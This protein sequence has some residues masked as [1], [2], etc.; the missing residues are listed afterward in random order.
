MVPSPGTGK[1]QSI[2]PLAP[3]GVF[4]TFLHAQ[5]STA[6]LGFAQLAL[7]QPVGTADTDAQFHVDLIRFISRYHVT[8][9]VATPTG[10]GASHIRVLLTS[11]LGAPQRVGRVWVWVVR[12]SSIH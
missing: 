10:P 11:T 4:N 5:F 8:D 1:S 3:F 12:P 6:E 2:A 7:N 9:V